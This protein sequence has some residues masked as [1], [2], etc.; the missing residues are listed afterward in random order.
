MK[1]A[2]YLIFVALALVSVILNL[3][4]SPLYHEEPRRGVVALEMLFSGNYVTPTIMG[5]PYYA[6][7]P[8]FNW[9]L[10]L[11]YKLLGSFSEF[12]T[13]LPS[14][15]S[16]ILI[17]LFHFLFFKKF[18]DKK[19]AF[20]SA[21]FFITSGNIYF[22]FSL[23]GEIDIFYS[24]V[25]YLCIISI[26]YFYQ[27][28]RFFL[29]FLSSFFLTA[30]GFL[31]KGFPSLAFLYVSLLVFL[32]SERNLKKLL[33][34]YHLMGIATLVSILGMYFYFYRLQ[35]PLE[36]YLKSIWSE[37]SQRTVLVDSF[38]ALFKHLV[39]F[40]L[41]TLRALLPYSI[42][43]LFAFRRG[44]VR[45]VLSVPVI[46]FSFLMF[47]SN[48]LVYLASPGAN[49][50]YVYMLFPFVLVVICHFYFLY[51]EADTTR[52]TVIN[53]LIR[54]LLSSLAIAA[55]VVPFLKIGSSVPQL[56]SVSACLFIVFSVMVVVSLKQK[57]D[58]I[59]I[60]LLIVIVLRLAFDV[61][62]LPMQASKLRS[63]EVKEDVKKIVE[64][65][66]NGNLSLY[67]DK[68]SFSNFFRYIFYIE[69]RR[70][71]VLR[72]TLTLQSGDYYIANEKYR[73]AADAEILFRF[74]HE[75][76]KYGLFRCK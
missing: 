32:A 55:L 4:L 67:G 74:T 26:F 23:I 69:S 40:P 58:T 49:Q 76:Q 27:S 72:R 10:I 20:Y 46:R 39:E 41:E 31:T 56:I 13:R 51:R 11:S 36:P 68:E 52:R 65:S 71:E 73:D 25:T 28:G 75:Q 42:L 50:R 16:L 19:I 2:G 57:A 61:A 29:L 1:R 14:I 17:G 21:M 48:Y 64:I 22:Y 38:Y 53:F 37:S 9:M 3:G 5:E 44:F 6:K 30:V 15:I 59:P 35:S 7:P 12:A 47:V 8:L 54:A 34:F 24:L 70:R 62:Y 63:T 60:L 33:S 45:E 18:L 66:N 43:S